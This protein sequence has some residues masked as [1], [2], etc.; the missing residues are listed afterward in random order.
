MRIKRTA[1]ATV[2]GIMAL[3]MYVCKKQKKKK[4]IFLKF[5]KHYI[6]HTITHEDSSIY[7]AFE[8]HIFT[9][10]SSIFK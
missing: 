3:C 7:I 1:T 9:L 6:L 5:L 4:T 10:S 8:C 2:S